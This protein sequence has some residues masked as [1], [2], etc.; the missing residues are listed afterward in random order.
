[1]K[2]KRLP[3]AVFSAF[4]LYSCCTVSGAVKLQALLISRNPMVY[5]NR[6]ELSYFGEPYY[7]FTQE[8]SAHD[9]R[10]TL[11]VFACHRYFIFVIADYV[12]F[13]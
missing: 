10:N 7:C 8:V 12:G 4:V 6:T 9:T 3:F 2:R 5:L 11:G 1:M 13:P